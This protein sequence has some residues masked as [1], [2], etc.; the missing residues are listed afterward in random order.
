MSS[1]PESIIESALS[2][3]F[4]GEESSE[5]GVPVVDPIKNMKS[6][7]ARKSANM[8]SQLANTQAQLD[9]LMQQ[10]TA[11]A[12]QPKQKIAK[13][14][15]YDNPEEFVSQVEAR[16]VARAEQMINQKSQANMQLQNVVND[17]QSK[18]SEFSETGS[19]AASLA[20]QIA[21]KLPQSIR[22]TAEG[23]EVAMMR[24]VAQLGLTPKSKKVPS[25]GDDFVGTSS[26]SQKAP[27]ARGRQD[28][29]QREFARLL[30]A[31]LN[32]KPTAKEFEKA[33]KRSKWT[34]PV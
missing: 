18:Y 26:G 10:L 32:N 1:D 9:Q 6:E 16:A 31:D 13:D 8:E 28:Q 15:I 29:L 34:D 2:E 22:G 21:S 20:L 25:A 19:E 4:E 14:L 30:G 7:F 23:A 24:A 11:N 12:Q 5:Q 27:Q 3:G 33:Q 17:I